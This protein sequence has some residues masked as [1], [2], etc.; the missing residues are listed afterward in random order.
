MHG[1][2][3]TDENQ[4]TSPEGFVWT[5]CG[6]RGTY[7]SGCVQVGVRPE[8]APGGGVSEGEGE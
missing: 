5:C 8:E 7:A 6:A 1:P 3:D 4:E 2:I